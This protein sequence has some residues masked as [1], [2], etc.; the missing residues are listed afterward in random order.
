MVGTIPVIRREDTWGSSQDKSHSA[1]LSLMSGS[2]HKAPC[3][4][5]GD[6]GRGGEDCTG[7]QLRTHCMCRHTAGAA[8]SAV[9][10]QSQCQGSCNGGKKV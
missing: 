5:V 7:V 3:Q 9:P 4:S 10:L 1:Q 6:G 2:L 8:V